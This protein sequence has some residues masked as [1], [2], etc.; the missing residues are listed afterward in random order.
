MKLYYFK[1]PHGNFGDDLNPWL[2]KQLI[3]DLLDQDDGEILVGIG[4]LLNHRLPK[5]G[6]LHIMGS[7]A[8]YGEKMAVGA[9]CTFHAV[10]GHQTAKMLGLPT[11]AVVTDAAVLIRET[12]VPASTLSRAKVGVMFTGQSLANYDWETLCKQEGWVFISCH[13][14]V[15]RV[16]AEM[17]RC[18]L[19]LTEAMHGAIVADALRVPW[20]PITCNRGIL[21][22]KW[23]DWLSSLELEYQ[24]SAIEPLYDVDA[25]MQTMARV[26]T[27]LKRY[28]SSV[29]F[30]REHWTPAPP[31]SSRPAQ[32]Q[33]AIAQLHQAATRAGTLSNE[34]LLTSKVQ[35]F[36]ELLDQLRSSR[37]RSRTLD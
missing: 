31:R 18:D 29:G 24:P 19:L 32:I 33:T 1:D 35:R 26:K 23:K 4:T 3:P 12:G 6:Q 22:S 28:A 16:F 36:V 2:W 14:S 9:H 34:H 5:S 37:S 15:E 8:G 10:R 27:E 25:S 21:S 17:Q 20:V 30:W 11:S 13:W 7:G